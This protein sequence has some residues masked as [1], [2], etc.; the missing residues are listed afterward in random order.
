MF[1]LEVLIGEAFTIDALSWEERVGQGAELAQTKQISGVRI[2]GTQ[3]IF[4]V[5]P[6]LVDY[7]DIKVVPFLPSGLGAKPY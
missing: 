1:Q 4:G 7:T 5:R 2:P 3:P 6:S